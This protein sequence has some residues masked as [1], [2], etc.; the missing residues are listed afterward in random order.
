MRSFLNICLLTTATAISSAAADPA[1]LAQL[2]D[3][4]G[5]DYA[6]A[7]ENGEIISPAEYGEM[8]EFSGV[9]MA[10][11]EALESPDTQ[12]TLRPLAQELASAIDA[13]AAP[14]DI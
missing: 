11:I 7:V 9:I 2:I 3:Y 6:V 1:R 10:E 4:V 14:A 13:K 8:Q 12:A 5:V